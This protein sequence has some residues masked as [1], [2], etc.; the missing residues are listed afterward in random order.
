M[1][2]LLI[3]E[4]TS[5]DAGVRFHAAQRLGTLNDARATA[6]LIASLGDASEK[7]QYAALSSLV[8]MKSAEALTPVVTMLLAER[9]SRVWG[10]LKMSIGLRLRTGLLEMVQR[11]DEGLSDRLFAA[12]SEQDVPVPF[13]EHQQ[14]LFVRLIGRTGDARRID[15]LLLLLDAD[16]LALRVATVE[17]L[18]YLRHATAVPALSAALSDTADSIRETAAEALGRIGDASAFNGVLAA[19]ADSNEWVRRAAAEAL[20]IFGDARAVEALTNALEDEDAMVQDAAFEALKKLST[21]HFT[22]IL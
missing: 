15:D 20:G 9:A 10:L 21:D 6:P 16:S 17:A 3:T 13:D 12:L 19:L 18:G 4:L 14:G 1:Y 22:T 11:G 2:E 5:A 7:V 8:K